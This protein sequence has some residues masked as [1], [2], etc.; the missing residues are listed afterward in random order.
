MLPRLSIPLQN[1]PLLTPE[2]QSLA[3]DT[4]QSRR[5]TVKPAVDEGYHPPQLLHFYIFCPHL[6]KDEQHEIDQ[7]LYRW[8]AQVASTHI[9][10]HALGDENTQARRFDDNE[11]LRDIGLAQAMASFS[12]YCFYI[13]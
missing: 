3:S 10:D 5:R 12:K 1:T 9:S 13:S 6:A 4:S 2:T 8:H 7:L 11:S